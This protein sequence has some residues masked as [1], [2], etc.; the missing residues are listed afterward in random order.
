MR[1]QGSLST[2]RVISVK[3]RDSTNLTKQNKNT[4]ERR[5]PEKELF[6]SLKCFCVYFTRLV[7]ESR[8]IFLLGRFLLPLSSNNPPK[9]PCSGTSKTGPK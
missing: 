8:V 5:S 1:N 2:E 7:R 3:V 9:D 6:Y 4:M